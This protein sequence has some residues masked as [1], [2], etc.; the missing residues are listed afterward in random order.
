MVLIAQCASMGHVIVD[1]PAVYNTTGNPLPSDIEQI[2]EWVLNLP[3]GE[4]NDSTYSKVVS[5][6]T[7]LRGK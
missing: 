5:G 6:T 4:A 7:C 1:E 3:F 2:M